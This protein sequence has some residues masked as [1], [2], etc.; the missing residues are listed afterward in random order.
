MYLFPKI[1]THEDE[2]TGQLFVLNNE[3][4]AVFSDKKVLAI[5]VKKIFPFV[6]VQNGREFYSWKDCFEEL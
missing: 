5:P 6:Y 4:T 1:Y 3:T 2:F